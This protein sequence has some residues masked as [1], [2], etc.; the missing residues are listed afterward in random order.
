MGG[1][2]DALHARI[3]PRF[4]R[5]EPRRR[6]RAYLRACSATVGR[7]NGGQ[8]AEHARGGPHDGCSGC[9]PPPPGTRPGPGRLRAQVVEH[10]GDPERWWGG[11][12]RVL[13]QGATSGGVHRQDAGTAGTVDNCQLG[14]CSPMPAEPGGVPR[15]GAVPPPQLD[16]G[17]GPLPGRPRPRAGRVPD[18]APAGPVLLERA[19]TPRSRLVGDRRGGL[20][21]RPGPAGLAGGPRQLRWAGRQGHRAAGDGHPGSATATQLAA[22]V[23]AE[24]WV[25]GSAGH[26]RQGPPPGPRGTHPAGRPAAAR[27]GALAC[28]A[29]YGPAAASLVGLVRVAGTRWVVEGFQQAKG[30]VGLDPDEV[31]RW[32]GW[33]RHITLALLA[34]AFLVVTH[35]TASGGATG[36]AAA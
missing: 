6:G 35:T 36:D 29:C 5:T 15:P 3:A 26:E 16:R 34:H 7:K 23:P 11:R 8:L 28:S 1:G 19:L 20:R 33:Y 4:A 31:R 13:Q 30:E 17:S 14:S 21:R 12:D 24:Q 22:S 32:P 10:L 2:R 9:W 27:D 25:A 18:Q